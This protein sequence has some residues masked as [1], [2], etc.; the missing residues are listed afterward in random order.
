M[1]GGHAGEKPL[2]EQ[3]NGALWGG[4]IVF[5]Q[6]FF[7]V[8]LAAVWMGL[9]RASDNQPVPKWLG[10]AVVL[11]F[12]GTACVV[13]GAQALAELARRQALPV[14]AASRPWLAAAG[15]TVV[16]QPTVVAVLI[17]LVRVISLAS[18]SSAG[19][20]AADGGGM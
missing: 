13:I 10:L 16:L 15:I 6:L 17:L 8:L 3:T 9:G 5:P 7:G 11:G 2:D 1:P 19:P 12:S 18:G 14:W 20:V 4:R